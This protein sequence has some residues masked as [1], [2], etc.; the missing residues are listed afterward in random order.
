MA[1]ATITLG[2]LRNAAAAALE[3][4]AE[5]DPPVLVDLVDSL[6]PPAL[7]I[8]WDDPWLEAGAGRPTLGPCLWTARLRV[9]C[10]AGRLEPG[11]GYDELDRL[12]AYVLERMRGDAYQWTLDQ[13]SAPAQYDLSGVTYLSSFVIYTVPTTV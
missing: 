6:T 4:V 13:V 11:P 9:V 3:P 1:V 12:V 2:E 10:V 8:G 5:E 7:M